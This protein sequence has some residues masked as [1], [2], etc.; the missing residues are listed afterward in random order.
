MDCTTSFVGI[1]TMLLFDCMVT[2]IGNGQWLSTRGM[3]IDHSGWDLFCQASVN[4]NRG[5]GGGGG[6]K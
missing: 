5:M 2:L 4:A 1:L 6:E 3:L